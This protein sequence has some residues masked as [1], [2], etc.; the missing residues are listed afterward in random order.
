MIFLV[1]MP[2][3]ILCDKA[4]LHSASTV[5]LHQVSH[6][7]TCAVHHA[8]CRAST[9]GVVTCWVSYG[10]LREPVGGCLVS[11]PGRWQ[12][13][14]PP[15]P[16]LVVRAWRPQTW[17]ADHPARSTVSSNVDSTAVTRRIPVSVV[18]H[19][20][21]ALPVWLGT[22][23]LPPPESFPG[24]VVAPWGHRSKQV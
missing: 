23:R 22:P 3:T 10:L 14:R 4:L 8:P 9:T 6:C 19:W 16:L 11:T 20:V 18:R 15:S 1:G 2:L 7:L 21:V 13:G 5:P 12:L 17:S 24:G